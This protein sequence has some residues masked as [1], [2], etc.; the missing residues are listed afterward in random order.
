V[1]H[2]VIH[3]DGHKLAPFTTSMFMKPAQDGA[4]HHVTVY[5]TCHDVA[6]K[7]NQTIDDQ[8]GK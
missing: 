8:D 7:Y 6:Q 2:T 4:I 1:Y 3:E 5:E